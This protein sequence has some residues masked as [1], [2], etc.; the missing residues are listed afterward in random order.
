MGRGARKPA[1]FRDLDGVLMLDKAYGISSNKALQEVRHLFKAK[2]AG[3]CGSL[4]PLATGVL[5]I[6]FGEATK[7]SSYLLNASK[8]YRATC[9]L[10]E[11]TDTGDAEGEI[12]LS[13]PI[14]VSP[15]GI[16]AVL[17]QFLGD[18]EQ[19]PPMHSALKHKG[20]RLY[21]L[22]RRGKTVERRARPIR[23]HSI[24]LVSYDQPYLVFDVHCSKGTYIRSLA[25]DIGEALGCGAFLGGLHRQGVAPFWDEASYEINFLRRLATLG[26]EEIDKRLLPISQSLVLF[27]QLTLTK[28]ASIGVMQGKVVNLGRQASPGM[29]R[30]M[31][32]SDRFIGLGELTDDG[33][34]IARRLMNTAR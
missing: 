6:C 29:Y 20:T 21:D 11:T 13:R 24:Q 1:D 3:H 26:V 5:P 10:G 12:T 34:L 30:L 16:L 18:L 14:E 32:E 27:P 33:R 9:K 2:K 23:I 15:Q 17:Q 28:A 8:R 22:A 31:S 25:G 19:I 7:Y 4:D